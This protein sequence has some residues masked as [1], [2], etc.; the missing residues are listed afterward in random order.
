MF[1]SLRSK[2]LVTYFA[3]MLSLSLLNILVGVIPSTMS[4][5][6]SN[7][8][9]TLL[10]QMV[11]MGVIPIVGCVLSKPRQ[12]QPLGAYAR[13]L[14]LNWRYHAPTNPKI[15][16]LMVPLCFS[17]YFLT[18]LVARIGS[19]FLLLTQ[20]TFTVNP[21]VIYT[22]PADLLKWI[23]LG[24]LLP[25]VFE[26]L[27]HRGLLLDAMF[28]R[29][30]EVEMV[31]L[32]GLLFAAMHTNIIQ[33]LYAFV[34]GCLL[35]FVV[36]KTNSIYPAMLLHFANNAFSHIQSYASQHPDG[37]LGWV[38]RINA[39]FTQ[40]V[41]GILLSALLL[42]ANMVACVWLLSALQ[43]VCGKPEGLRERWIL[44]GKRTQWF[45]VSL[46]TYRPYGKATLVDNAFLWAV[47]GMT[48]SM[49]VFTYV[50]GILR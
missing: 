38:E 37:A 23:A 4:D 31:L 29:G 3:S 12:G 39:F 24:A 44:R 22:E 43:R 34:G 20:Y 41:G 19:L 5:N 11:C 40:S 6:N 28:D 2:L 50:W 21:D 42:V 14:A 26:E 15:W 10:S 13:T 27:T 47:L 18:H 49:T 46:D 7:M 25:A 45:A 17:F 16:W 32:S 30:N 33:F 35:A 8:L 9:F 36:V 48:V 1:V